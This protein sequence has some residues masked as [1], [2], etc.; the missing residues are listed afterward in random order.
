MYPSNEFGVGGLLDKLRKS[1][2]VSHGGLLAFRDGE[3]ESAFEAGQ[4][5][6]VC[7]RRIRRPLPVR[8]SA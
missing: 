5:L 3:K 6:L 8:R 1:S 2:G 7:G 4:K